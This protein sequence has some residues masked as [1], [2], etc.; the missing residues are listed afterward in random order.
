MPRRRA[1]RTSPLLLFSLPLLSYLSEGHWGPWR[2][3]GQGA[4]SQRRGDA[5]TGALERLGERSQL[6]GL[7]WVRVGVGRRREQGLPLVWCGFGSVL[8]WYDSWESLHAQD[9]YW[10]WMGRMWGLRSW[11]VRREGG[12]AIMKREER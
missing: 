6:V 2:G 12:L 9:L 11:K 8:S 10:R 5:S 3:L 1:G 4:V 7:H